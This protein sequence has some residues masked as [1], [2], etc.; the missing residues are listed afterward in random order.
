MM[1]DGLELYDP[2]PVTN[3]LRSRFHHAFAHH[4]LRGAAEGDADVGGAARHIQGNG[5]A[6]AGTSRLTLKH[7]LK[8]VLD[9]S[10][11]PEPKID[12]IFGIIF[13]PFQLQ[14]ILC[15]D[16]YRNLLKRRLRRNRYRPR[17]SLINFPLAEPITVRVSPGRLAFEEQHTVIIK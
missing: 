13:S 17:P 12:Y 1:R 16:R 10:P 4:P 11:S 14:S 9:R 5:A 6:A 8:I 7:G 15:S 3:H 2:E